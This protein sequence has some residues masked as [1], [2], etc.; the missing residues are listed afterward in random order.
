MSDVP[1]TP[2]RL[3][4][5][6]AATVERLE[7]VLKRKRT[8]LE[9]CEARMLKYEQELADA[10]ALLRRW[11]EPMNRGEFER[12]KADTCELFTRSGSPA[13]HITGEGSR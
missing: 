6:Y 5:G 7:L 9:F 10:I 8:D 3:L 4:R 11:M 13:G 12:L 2:E 1:L